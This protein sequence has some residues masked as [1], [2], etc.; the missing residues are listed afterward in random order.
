MLFRRDSLWLERA[1]FSM[2]LSSVSSAA[3][4]HSAENILGN[5]FCSSYSRWQPIIVGEARQEQLEAAR[6]IHGYKQR[7]KWVCACMFVFVLGP[8]SFSIV[9]APAHKLV[10][11]PTLASDCFNAAEVI[12]IFLMSM[13]MGQPCSYSFSLCVFP[14]DSRLYQVYQVG[15][16]N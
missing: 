14:N 2:C 9:H 12:K 1:L 8:S 10:V 11:L 15:N 3:M 6:H 16:Q 7:E 13:S 5:S 4:R